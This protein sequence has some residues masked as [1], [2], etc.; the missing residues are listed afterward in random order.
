MT[1][2]DK[3]MQSARVIIFTRFPVPGKAKTRLI[4][5]LGAKG[6]ADLH[7]RMTEFTIKQVSRTGISLQVRF[8]GGSEAQM[9]AWLGDAYDY[10]PQGDGDLGERMASA[11][12]EAFTQAAKNVLVIGCDCPDNRS[13]NIRD[14]IRALDEVP[15]V[16][17]PAAD[18]GYYLIGLT[19]PC[20]GL[21]QNVDWGTNAV[22]RQTI[23]KIDAYRL[24]PVMSDVDAPGD[25]PLKISVI[26]PVLN[27]ENQIGPVVNQVLAGFNTEA[28]VVDGGSGDRTREIA[29]QTGARVFRSRPGRALQM[30]RGARQAAGDILLFLHADSDL[31][32]AW[33]S[34]VRH[35]M[36]R[37]RSALGYFRFAINGLFAGRRLVEWGANMRSRLLKSP[38]GDQGLFLRRIDF[39]GWGGFPE[40]PIL[41]D[42]FLVNKAKKRGRVCCTGSKLA[43]S[44]RRWM[45][46]GVV[47]TTFI[48]QAVLLL[49][50]LGADLDHLSRAYRR[51]ENPLRALITKRKDRKNPGPEDQ[52]PD[53]P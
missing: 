19:G 42:V 25:I 46:Y 9:Q 34:H 18:G 3:A 17:G 44:G 33:D 6:A 41:E 23:A 29:C 48:N 36:K 31:P 40:V 38:Y 50:W 5:S 22:L 51:G 26:I 32:P 24:L 37:P 53:S 2:K 21:F 13:A 16:I 45:E 35:V 12:D 47:R 49:A 15:C 39:I 7:R 27:E 30:N 43:T 1:R 10:A 8:T 11:F 14:A 28:I 52:Y 4:P 20:P